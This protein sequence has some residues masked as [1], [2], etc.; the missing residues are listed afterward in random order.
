MW[1]EAEEGA[2]TGKGAWKQILVLLVC[3]SLSYQLGFFSCIS[4]CLLFLLAA[5]SL[6]CRLFFCREAV[7]VSSCL[8]RGIRKEC[9]STYGK[10]FP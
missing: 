8:F 9:V 10:P 4:K 3:S 1:H 5:S 7:N 6:L 2:G